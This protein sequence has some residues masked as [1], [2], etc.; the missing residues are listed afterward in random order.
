MRPFKPHADS[1]IASRS[2]LNVKPIPIVG[3]IAEIAHQLT[4]QGFALDIPSGLGS[5][6]SGA[7]SQNGGG[8]RVEQ[9]TDFF[10]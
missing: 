9:A 1:A 5:Q 8:I 6:E 4:S 3:T 2:H 7:R 10:G